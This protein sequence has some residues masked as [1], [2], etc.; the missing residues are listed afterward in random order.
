MSKFN[1]DIERFIVLGKSLGLEKEEL[2]KFVQEQK[3]EW[4]EKERMEREDRQME[5][6]ERERERIAT[7]ELAE[8]E[9]ERERLK[10]EATP[11]RGDMQRGDPSIPP[12]GSNIKLKLPVFQD[13]RD[14]MDAYLTSFERLMGV[15]KIPE[16]D[17]AVNLGILLTGKARDV[18]ARLDNVDAINYDKL[19]RALLHRYEL[20]EEGFRL[21]FR[22]AQIEDGETYTQ[23]LCRVRGYA[24][25]WIKLSGI[26]MTYDDLFDLL[27]REQLLNSANLDLTFFLK[28]RIPENASKMAELA[29]TFVEARKG[30]M[31]HRR[32]D[33]NKGGF[34]Q[35]HRYGRSSGENREVSK[36]SRHSLSGNDRQSESVTWQPRCFIC[37]RKGHLAKS[38]PNRVKK[39]ESIAC[40]MNLNKERN[41]IKEHDENMNVIIGNA[42]GKDV[43]IIRDTGCSTVVLK[44][45]LV[46]ECAMTGK[47]GSYVGLDGVVKE[48]PWCEI[49]LR[50]PFYTGKVTALVFDNPIYDVVI[51]NIPGA[52]DV[53]QPDPTWKMLQIQTVGVMETRAQMKEKRTKPLIMPKV[54]LDVV[55]SEEMKAAQSK[56]VS[57]RK[58]F[59]LTEMG[60][61]KVTGK[62]ISRFIIRK[63]L[64]MREFKSP[65]VE[66][67][68][69]FIQLVV[70]TEMRM[71][72]MKVGHETIMAGHLAT[73][74]SVDRI[75][76]HFYWPGLQSDVH[77]FCQSCD[78]CQKTIPKGRVGKAVLGRMPIIDI[79]FQRIA[80]D[81]VGPIEPMTE[82]KNRYILTIVDYATRYPEAVPL[83]R[84]DTE[85]VAE[86]L[87]EVFSRVGIP[88]EILTDMGTQF[89]SDLMKEV[90][91]LLSLHQ[92]TTTP[93][94]PMCNGLV[95]RFNGTLKAMLKK[96]CVERPKDWDRY[97]APLLFAYREV[98]QESL[99]FSPFELLYGR[100][101]RG[102]MQI[103]KELWSGEVQDQDVKTTYEYVL[104]LR[105][106]LEKTC[107]IANRELEKASARYR[108][109]FNKRAKDRKF[110]VNDKVLLLLP[111]QNNKLL[112]KWQGPFVIKEKV[113]S[114]D[115]RIEINGKRKTYHVNLL[116]KYVERDNVERKRQR[117]NMYWCGRRR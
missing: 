92:L 2:Q 20:T 68:K 95:E 85:T 37:E 7:K 79:P 43:K 70:P 103:L 113:G 77:R 17:W 84:I 72:V 10:L 51:G 112:M 34:R 104:D 46:P 27:L 14:D 97:V 80:I 83:A 25:R 59:L 41:I 117:N 16:N 44:K 105:E 91:R 78:T 76:R 6:E 73:R 52:R 89:T 71:Q 45:S 114:L 86:A 1:M 65:K 110:N 94:H 82:R 102:P 87:L 81:L 99:G 18:Y 49:Y 107:E 31:Q 111:M 38:C 35:D 40:I 28:E 116:K 12:R 106:R 101:V 96:M 3:E 36:Y 69:L 23:Y 39:K 21:K 55:N 54:K 9:L 98:P 47:M 8:L 115:Y 19:K 29:E 109:N 75:Q 90:G 93:Y 62:N 5:R 33:E 58:L 56:D 66:N 26:E 100:T 60:V 42:F 30:M 13:G 11:G 74:K 64:L 108:G 15:Q 63:G 4:R 32:R 50:M 24:Q 48:Q 88:N 57:L 61:E 67:G 22:N 53:K